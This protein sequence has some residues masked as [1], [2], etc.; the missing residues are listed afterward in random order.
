M[1]WYLILILIFFLPLHIYSGPVRSATIAAAAIVIRTPE[2]TY[3]ESQNIVQILG[4]KIVLQISIDGCDNTTNVILNYKSPIMKN[5]EQI[6]FLPK[7]SGKSYYTGSA[8]IQPNKISLGKINFYIVA[9]DGGCGEVDLYGSLE[10][11]K[12]INVSQYN[13]KNIGKSGGNISL[14][15]GNPDDGENNLK[16]P[17]GAIN[18]NI[19]ITFKQI[20]PI[21]DE[22][23][24]KDCVAVYMIEPANIIFK[25]FCSL[26]LLYFDLNND[27]EVDGAD[28]NEAELKLC[29]YDGYEWRNLGGN[30][31]ATKNLV[32]GNIFRSGIYGLIPADKIK[33]AQI[34]PEERIVTPNGDGVND[35]LFFTG[36]V[37]VS[38]FKITIFNINGSIIRIITDMPYWDGKDSHNRY[39]PSG[40]YLYEVEA[41]G[42]IVKGVCAIAK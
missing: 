6:P 14:R 35:Y 18:N 40:V 41:N 13:S 16:F 42:K 29:W 23:I 3:D 39:V 9:Y 7:P 24:Y 12:I 25:K 8:T 22:N 31:N 19:L 38:D 1:K 5:Y 36:L 37:N 33:A 11:P 28:I 27:G 20:Y 4:N 26:T 34:K 10:S 30:V 21:P 17:D 15:D 32:K 2:V